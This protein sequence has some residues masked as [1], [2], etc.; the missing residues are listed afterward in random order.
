MPAAAP[1]P[2]LIADQ[3]VRFCD[4]LR[5]EGLAIGTA[6]ILDSLA[7]VEEVPWS[8]REQFRGALAATLAKSQEDRRLFDLVVDR[9]FFRAFDRFLVFRRDGSV[10]ESPEPVYG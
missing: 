6:E 10:I 7:A 8:E 9:W 2:D 1:G 5:S 3:L 4:E